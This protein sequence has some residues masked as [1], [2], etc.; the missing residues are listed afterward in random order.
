MSVKVVA[1]DFLGNEF[2]RELTKEDLQS[3]YSGE[4]NFKEIIRELAEQSETLYD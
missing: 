4:L 1:V 3:L 2:K